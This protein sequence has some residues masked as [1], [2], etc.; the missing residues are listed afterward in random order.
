MQQSLEFDFNNLFVLD[1]ANN[2]QGNLEHGLNIIRAMGEQ[3]KKHGV[4]AGLKFQFRQLDSFIHP[5][6]Q[7]GSTAKHIPRFLDTRM[8]ANEYKELMKEI[9]AQGMFS[10]ST[11]FDEE[12]VA[13]IIDMDIDILKIASCSAQD[14]P[15]LE[16]A[17]ESGKPI[18]CSTGGL[19]LQ[20]IDSLYSFF[21]HRGVEFALMHCVAIYP[22]PAED[23]QLN[24]LDLF[25]KRYPN[26]TIGWSTHEDQDETAPVQIAYAKGA[27]MFERHVGIETDEIKLNKYSSTPAQIDKW[28][29]A[30]NTA[31]AMCGQEEGR[32]AAPQ[33]ETEALQSLQRGVYAKDDLPAGTKLSRDMVY[34]AMPIEEGQFSSGEFKEGTILK[35]E[36]KKDGSLLIENL[37]LLPQPADQMIKKSI[38]EIKAMLHEAGV[39]LNADFQTEYSHHY[40]VE[41]F[42]EI[43]AVLIDIVNR[44]YCKKI[45]VQLPGQVHP[46][47]YHKLKEETFQVISGELHVV[48]EGKKRHLYPGD[49][50][51]IQPG[52]WHAFRTD[53]GCVF[54]EIS[55]KHYNDDSYY[56]DKKINAMER[57][58]RKTIV[59]HWGRYELPEKIRR[60][61]I[62]SIKAA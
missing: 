37:K 46:Q 49:T 32:P 13:W 27:R 21:T 62:K 15:L 7:K 4:R 17:A 9:K 40:G 35:D 16:V 44:D 54:E 30:Y 55:T 36:V 52:M 25:Q 39:H 23:L 41:N 60:K 1:L 59:N 3:A 33:V 22:T 28:F 12:S 61:G 26:V 43:G 57:S 38:H 47:H 11:P 10:I 24:Q 8:G 6:H 51:L 58:E 53:T 42:R 14:W 5:A 2:H 29:A 45:I 19:S 48:L 56:K 18:I 20:Q 50:C 31:V 34:F